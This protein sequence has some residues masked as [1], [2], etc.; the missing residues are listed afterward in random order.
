LKRRLQALADRH[1]LIGAVRGQGLL[2]GIE[3][4]DRRT[5]K[6]A[7]KA[8]RWVINDLCG[9][10]VLVGLTGPDRNSR[11][12]LKIRPPLVFDETAVE[13]LVTTLDETLAHCEIE[14]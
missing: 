12:I 2:L 8:A 5:R 4:T 11:N 9:R 1:P 3:L 14:P 6:P 13:L 7:S 10:G